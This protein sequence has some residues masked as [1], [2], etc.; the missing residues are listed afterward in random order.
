MPLWHYFSRPDNLELHDLTLPSTDLPKSL[1]SVIG[2]GLKF[3]PVPT[4]LNRRP[5]T[6]FAR[7]R[8]DLLTKVYFSGR[9]NE[10]D[11]VFIPSIHFPST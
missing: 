1:K 8:K 10:S 7:F 9:P 3:C 4:I 6:T 11:E 5:T 2:L